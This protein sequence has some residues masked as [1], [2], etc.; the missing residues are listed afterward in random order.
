ML[1]KL[2]KTN[3]A[4]AA[5][6]RLASTYMRFV[7]ATSRWT[8]IGR[9][10]AEGYWDRKEPFV[11]AFWHGRILMSPF[12]WDIKRAGI[13]VMISQHRDGDLI[14]NSVKPFGIGAI[15]GS[16]AKPGRKDKGGAAALRAMVKEIKAGGCVGFTPDGPRGPAEEAGEGVVLLARLSGAPIIPFAYS[17]SRAKRARSWDRFFVALPFS[18][19]YYVWGAPIHVARNAD[20][21]AI[22]TA[23]RQVEDG[24]RTVTAEADKLAGHAPALHVG[25]ERIAN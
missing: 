4:R 14:A 17:T 16:S 5:L 3:A 10:A 21:D 18:R 13:K 8:V 24:L 22:E 12:S 11:F 23:R 19:G 15:R 1:K 7:H 20:A 6:T 9:E 25:D 2:L